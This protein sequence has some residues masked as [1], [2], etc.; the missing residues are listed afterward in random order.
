MTAL[1]ELACEACRAGAPTVTDDERDELMTHIP[2][3]SVVTREG[4]ARLEREFR[5]KDFVAALAFTQRVGELAEAFGHHPT[6]LTAWGRVTVTWWSHKIRG[7]HK[8]DFIM[9]AKTDQVYGE[10]QPA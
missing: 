3:W 6:I 9:A 4:I 10:S 8:T 2:E 1:H 5:F 7:L